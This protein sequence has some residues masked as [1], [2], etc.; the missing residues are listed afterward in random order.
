M[1]ENNKNH[2][3]GFTLLELLVVVLI[4]GILAAIALPQY[5]MA[6]AKT[7]FTMLKTMTKSIYE[8]I[9]RYYLTNNAYPTNQSQLD[10]AFEGMQEINSNS[11]Y[12]EFSTSEGISCTV[13]IGGNHIACRRNIFGK[14]T[15]Y[16]A[17]QQNNKP[18]MCLTYS[19]N[20]SDMANKLCQKETNR[21]AA[22]SSCH[23][24]Y[25]VYGY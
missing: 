11:S 5:K 20:T 22:Q 9:Q 13:W 3:S 1:K 10:I 4:I 2:K 7:K 12:F 19:T 16:Y 25:C 23:N 8:S 14:T 24:G 17:K 18:S 21:T 6:V 15:Y